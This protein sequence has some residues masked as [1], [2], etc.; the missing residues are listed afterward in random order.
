MVFDDIYFPAENLIG[1]GNQ[2][3]GYFMEARAPG[4]V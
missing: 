1:E 2:D 3:F 4:C